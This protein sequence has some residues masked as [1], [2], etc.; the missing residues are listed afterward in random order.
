MLIR[1]VR[2][3]IQTLLIF[4]AAAEVAAAAE[5]GRIGASPISWHC[6]Q[7][8]DEAFNVL[9]APRMAASDTDAAPVPVPTWTAAAG[10]TAADMRPV[11]QR[12]DAEVFSASAWRVPLHSEPTDPTL[13]ETL[14]K[15]VL[16]GVHPACSVAYDKAN[17]RVAVR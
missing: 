1:A 16:C 6:V 14:L 3:V 13:V 4:S 11:A 5:L 7:E 10:A 15:S 17:L 9:C 8:H 12:G 2:G